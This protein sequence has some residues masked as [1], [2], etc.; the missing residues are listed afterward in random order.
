[1]A[2]SFQ[3]DEFA[4]DWGAPTQPG[5]VPPERFD[6]FA[7]VLPD[8]MLT[9]WREFGFSGFGDGMLWICDPVAWRPAVTEWTTNLELPMGDDTWHAVTRT[10]FGRLHLWGERTGMSLTIVPYRGWI[11]P[12]DKSDQM[13]TDADRNRQIYV[14]MLT[15]DKDFIDPPA[16]D[17]KPMFDRVLAAQGPVA[18][19]TVYGFVPALALGG[20]ALPDHVEIFDAEVHMHLL[21]ELTP[22]QIMTGPA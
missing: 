20:P 16:D 1:V 6:E 17:G 13:A 14:E 8:L 7:G 9:F 19:D 22:R 3:T 4:E 2:V 15:L 21:S 12:V 11:Q 5:A 10:A 18:A